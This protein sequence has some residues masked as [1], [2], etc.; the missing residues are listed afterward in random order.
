[1]EAAFREDDERLL[2]RIED[3]V[4]A[5][6]IWS[7]QAGIGAAPLPARSAG[8]VSLLRS[9]A[10]GAAAVERALSRD[11]GPI[12]ALLVPE[13]LAGWSPALI[14][15]TAVHFGRVA[16]VLE[17]SDPDASDA[18]RLR[19]V[20]AWLALGEERRYLEG[21]ARA[22]AG[23][24]LPAVEAETAGRAAALRPLEELGATARAGAAEHSEPA[25]RA[26]AMLR[27]LDRAARIGGLDVHATT[28]ITRRADTMRG[29]AISSALAPI[30]EA[31]ADAGARDAI[32]QEAPAIFERIRRVWI[33][34]DRDEQVERFGV[35]EATPLAWLAYRATGWDP[36]RAMVAP[37]AEMTDRMAERIEEDP[38]R[39]LAY[40]AKCAQF[41]VFRGECE[42]REPDR[43]PLVERALMICP[44]HRNARVVA[45]NFLCD[46]A[47]GLLGGT[48][49]FQPSALVAAE[50]AVQRA[51]TLF[52]QSKR[53]EK[54]KARLEE[55]RER[56]RGF[57]R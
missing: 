47:D 23:S 30:L 45:C 32:V 48:A 33:W 31:L 36:L 4:V 37:L 17:P 27:R 2:A 40:T 5:G 43:W 10:G 9:I 57:T 14:H 1:M 46:R 6:A 15:H 49:I 34:S 35:D 56:N 16:A 29:G 53:L 44:S 52:P 11:L 38:R 19:S 13:T 22:V 42:K 55:I 50:Q 21:L 7:R 8:M 26:L 12:L 3:E 54:S 20:A 51:E 18:A 41:L 24:A 39:H 25:R 28:S